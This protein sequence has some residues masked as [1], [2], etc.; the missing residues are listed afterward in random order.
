MMDPNLRVIIFAHPRSGSTSLNRILE[1][2]PAIRI[3]MEPFNE[4]Y[5][6]RGARQQGLLEPG[7][8]L[9]IAASA[10]GRDL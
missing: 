3:L 6:K 5:T 4:G 9:A 2:H 8:G 7:P 1:L 10:V